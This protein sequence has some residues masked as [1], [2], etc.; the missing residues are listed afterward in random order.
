M[1]EKELVLTCRGTGTEVDKQH[2]TV[3]ATKPPSIGQDTEDFGENPGEE[4]EPLASQFT[5]AM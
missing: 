4:K 5:S 2:Q 1:R 3:T